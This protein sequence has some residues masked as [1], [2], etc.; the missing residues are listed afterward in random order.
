MVTITRRQ[1]NGAAGGSVSLGESTLA[2]NLIIVALCVSGTPPLTVS[3]T[4]IESSGG[5]NVYHLVPFEGE[6]DYEFGGPFF[7]SG[8]WV[9]TIYYSIT[10]APTSGVITSSGADTIQVQEYEFQGATS[11]LYD[12]SIQGNNTLTPAFNGELLFQVS[13]SVT[14]PTGFT[15]F[16]NQDCPD[17]GSGGEGAQHAECSDL[18]SSTGAVVGTCNPVAFPFRGAGSA[19]VA[20]KFTANATV[21]PNN[22]TVATAEN[23]PNISAGVKTTPS[24]V[25]FASAENNPSPSAVVY[26][27]PTGV[28]FV[29]AENNPSISAGVKITPTGVVFDT[30]V[31]SPAIS[32]GVK[33]TPNGVEVVTDIGMV[34]AIVFPKLPPSP[35]QWGLGF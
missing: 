6:R 18:L 16:Q 32:A 3:Q 7:Y 29:S 24:G 2:G 25:V 21:T 1:Y 10:T 9:W 4:V 17:G 15:I 27:I 34:S 5:V 31:H 30:A 33:I 19:M 8:E 23:S 20:F 26:I 14:P 35:M 22:V 28:T 13:D 12:T 11:I